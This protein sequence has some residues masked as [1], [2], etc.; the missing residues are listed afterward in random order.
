M[1]QAL[2]DPNIDH[3]EKLMQNNRYRVNTGYEPRNLLNRGTSPNTAVLPRNPECPVH[4]N[5]GDL[6]GQIHELDKES[7]KDGM[8]DQVSE[9][10]IRTFNPKIISQN[11]PLLNSNNLGTSNDMMCSIGSMQSR[12]GV[13]SLL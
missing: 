12:K 6:L 8:S 1:W 9:S 5:Q 2:N 13:N 4:N 7:S 3:F 11:E 10:G